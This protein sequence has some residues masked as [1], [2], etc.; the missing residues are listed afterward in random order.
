MEQTLARPKPAPRDFMAA[1]AARKEAL[2]NLA[3]TL[4]RNRAMAERLLSRSLA[5]AE[6]E[7]AAFDR[8]GNF[9]AWAMRI[10]RTEYAAGLGPEEMVEALTPSEVEPAPAPKPKRGRPPKLERTVIPDDEAYRAVETAPFRAAIR[11]RP[12]ADLGPR[13]DLAWLPI[14][15]LRIDR[16]YQREILRRGRANVIRIADEFDWRMFVP[17]I[18]API[19]GTPF[20][21]MIDGQHRTTAAACCDIAEVPCMIAH[22]DPATQA[23]AFAAINGNVTL[24][25][26]LQLHA[27]RVAAGELDAKRLDDVCGSAGVEIL[28]YPVPSNNIRFGQTLAV[29]CL[30]RALT[31]FGSEVLVCALLC[32]T[33][34]RDGNVGLLRAPLIRG[35]CEVLAQRPQ[36]AADPEAAI[37][38]AEG[39]DFER[40]LD[41]A[42]AD[43]R[44]TRS[45]VAVAVRA[46]LA[47]RFGAA[48]R[49]AA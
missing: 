14:P 4:C 37:A 38:V 12:A 49:A 3:F 39:I 18:V 30:D 43:A 16:R 17:A 45:P 26:S 35:L 13:P 6:R 31:T 27:A 47:A 11:A 7:H 10:M 40:L 34:S 8:N 21:A 24:M 33:G 20:Y 5:R 25:S 28:R 46:R 23:A 15:L 9:A 48:D 41:D 36:L 2:R 22:A 32:L 44:R 19:E 42:G 1:L 29:G